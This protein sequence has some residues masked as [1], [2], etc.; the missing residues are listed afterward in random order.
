MKLRVEY[1]T[2]CK[3]GF[4]WYISTIGIIDDNGISIDTYSYG[5]GNSK[6]E[7]K[8]DAFKNL[9]IRLRK[10]VAQGDKARE[11]LKLLPKE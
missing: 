8:L 1:Q 6:K 7:A 5:Y 9:R 10:G 11:I 2:P 4:S 3:T